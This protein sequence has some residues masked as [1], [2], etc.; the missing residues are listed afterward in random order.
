MARFTGLEPYII[1]YHDISYGVI[2]IETTSSVGDWA[3]VS[4]GVAMASSPPTDDDLN[5]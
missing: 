5:P 4:I 2:V 1:Q 3:S